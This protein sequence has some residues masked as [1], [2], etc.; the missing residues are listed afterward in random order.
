MGYYPTG[1]GL[2]VSNPVVT[3]YSSG[4]L[5]YTPGVNGIYSS[6]YSGYTPGLGYN[7]YLPYPTSVAYPA[8]G[9]VNY[10]YAPYG[11]YGYRR[12]FVG[13]LGRRGLFW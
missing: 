4:Y 7:P 2:G 12:G 10:G 5:G 3:S 1:Y 11:M 8:F 6:A 9:S 13:G